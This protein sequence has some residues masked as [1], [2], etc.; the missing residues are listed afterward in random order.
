MTGT[1]SNLEGEIAIRVA[2]Q[3][4]RIADVAVASSRPLG[5][6]GILENR[7]P[8][9]SLT[10]LPMV[11]SLCG[12][13]QAV[14]GLEAVETAIGATV[15]ENQ[16]AA[17]RILVASEAVGQILWRVLLDIP[18]AIDKEPAFDAVRAVRA[19]LARVP[20]YLVPK[21]VWNRIGGTALTINRKGLDALVDRID[22]IIR[23]EVFGT[24]PGAPYP[25]GDLDAFDFW[26]AE[27]D[28]VPTRLLR[29]VGARRLNGFG[30]AE[31]PALPD[32][33]LADIAARLAAD[34]DRT[35]TAAPEIDGT[36]F[37]TGSLARHRDHPLIAEL[38]E[39]YG[40]G[41][42]TRFASKLVDLVWW[43]DELAAAIAAITDEATP[44][45]PAIT[46][47]AG[48]AAVE[49]ARG[50]LYHHVA[51]EDGRIARYRILAP[52]EWNFHARG[53]LVAGLEG[54][55]VRDPARLREATTL[56]VMTVDP[57]VAFD[58]AIA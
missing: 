7:T 31:T 16:K 38:A 8:A 29:A 26:T 24:E 44:A 30:A 54:A 45:T 6:S 33:A 28:T 18:T 1:L 3:G 52:T 36:V 23:C 37:E 34:D 47:G 56:F 55:R 50:R 57:C 11:F 49:T 42:T 15:S 25:I 40:S 46:S 4:G 32:L 43:R 27:H 22:G 21:D 12:N 17:R 10:V 53:P 5:A 58:L 41:L 35:F 51:I 9:E 20:R 14:C 39:E 48:T 13:A 2:S 19:S